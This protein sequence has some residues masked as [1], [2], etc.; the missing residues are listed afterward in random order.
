MWLRLVWLRLVDLSRAPHGT[1]LKGPPYLG[2]GSLIVVVVFVVVSPYL[3]PIAIARHLRTPV[4]LCQLEG[5]ATNAV[6]RP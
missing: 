4:C 2:N 1:F 3:P 5:L 6:R